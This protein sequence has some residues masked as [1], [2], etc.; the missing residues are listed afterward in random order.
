M[1]VIILLAT[2][3]VS[4]SP[5]AFTL[6][7]MFISTVSTIFIIKS[8][9]VRW[10]RFITIITFSS[11]IMALFVYTTSVTSNEINKQK[12]GTGYLF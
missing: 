3:V 1:V 11:G 2:R 6:T 5:L 9:I 12:K 10:I 7:V 8:L 4:I